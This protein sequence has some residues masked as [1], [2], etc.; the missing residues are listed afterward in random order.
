MCSYYDTV[1]N[2]GPKKCNFRANFLT[3]LSVAE[4][5]L[6]EFLWPIF[7]TSTKERSAVLSA[8]QLLATILD[9]THLKIKPAIVVERG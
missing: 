4:F 1:H 2:V 8:R 7:V 3:L 9:S 6:L 5:V